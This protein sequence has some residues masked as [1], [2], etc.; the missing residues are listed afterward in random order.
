MYQT[1]DIGSLV[2]HVVGTAP[3]AS[4]AG[5]INGAAID[6]KDYGSCVLLVATGAETGSPSARSATAKIQDSDDGSTGWA[7]L[8]GA[9][10][11]VSVVSSSGSVKVNLAG[12]KRYIRVVNTIALT[13]GT[14]PTLANS[15][16]VVLGGP[17]TIP[18]P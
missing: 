13:G 1:H 4:A 16:A 11:A 10:V 3:A 6:R 2:K 7:D 12:A 14:S 15:T 8:T 17:T 18:A 5:A 9:S